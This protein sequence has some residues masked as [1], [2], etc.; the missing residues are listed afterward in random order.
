MCHQR[1]RLH[2][3]LEADDVCL[4]VVKETTQAPVLQ[5]EV[6]YGWYLHSNSFLKTE[7]LFILAQMFR[8]LQHASPAS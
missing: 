2:V 6:P 4:M 5:D 3:Y 8:R 7:V 1:G